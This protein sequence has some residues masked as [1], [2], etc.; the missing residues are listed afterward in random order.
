MVSAV[1]S[2]REFADSI[3]DDLRH[4]TQSAYLRQDPLE[5]ILF[6]FGHSSLISFFFKALGKIWKM[7]PSFCACAVVITLDLGL[8]AIVR[9]GGLVTTMTFSVWFLR[10]ETWPDKGLA[11]YE[12]LEQAGAAVPAI[13]GLSI[14]WRAAVLT[15]TM[16]VRITAF[17]LMNLLFTS[18]MSKLRRRGGERQRVNTCI[19]WRRSGGRRPP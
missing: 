7:T 14:R 9:T 10:E 4:L 2:E 8:H 3:P 5:A 16:S 6:I 12:A 18:N 15:L 1:L 19:R 13:Q 17:W 11:Y